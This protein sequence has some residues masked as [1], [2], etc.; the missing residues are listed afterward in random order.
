MP[1]R[2]TS[3]RLSPQV[4]D[5]L[6]ELVALRGLS[7][8]EIVTTGILVQAEAFGLIPSAAASLAKLLPEPATDP[9]R[10]RRQRLSQR[11][12]RARRQGENV[13][14]RKPGP[15]RRPTTP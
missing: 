9:D 8:T 6:E 1:G 7:K 3:L 13:P 10:R 15:R 12:T 5:L 11:R 2:P 4:F 14:K